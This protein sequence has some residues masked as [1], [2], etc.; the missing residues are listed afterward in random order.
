MSFKE[1]LEQTE[2]M[3]QRMGREGEI[4]STFMIDQHIKVLED[5]L[6][7]MARRLFKTQET[8]PADKIISLCK[9]L[10]EVATWRQYLLNLK[11]QQEQQKQQSKIIKPESN[12]LVA[13]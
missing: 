3:M 12:L 13:K 6:N 7:G 11:A 4:K 5:K 1:R 8:L 2:A 10:S 9:E